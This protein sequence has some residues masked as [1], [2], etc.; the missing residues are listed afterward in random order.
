MLETEQE[1]ARADDRRVDVAQVRVDTTESGLA[2]TVRD[3]LCLLLWSH[4]V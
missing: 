3:G 1:I 2:E 4:A